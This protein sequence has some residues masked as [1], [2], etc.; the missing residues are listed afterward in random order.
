MDRWPSRPASVRGPGGHAGE[1]PESLRHKMRRAW[2]T[3]MAVDLDAVPDRVR[4]E[5]TA[6]Q[7]GLWHK[8]LA[9]RLAGRCSLAERLAFD[10]ARFEAEV[11]EQLRRLAE[12]GRTTDRH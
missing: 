11:D 9:D 2:L 10:L 1:Q 12:A 7:D 6:W 4:D 5:A 3:A 8:Y